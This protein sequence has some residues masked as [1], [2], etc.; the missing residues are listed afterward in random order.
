MTDMLSNYVCGTIWYS[1]Y[2]I[3]DTL[4]TPYSCVWTIINLPRVGGH[5]KSMHRLQKPE[6]V[7]ENHC[8]IQMLGIFFF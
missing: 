1:I 4:V 2:S 5:T 8:S 6:V 3:G 7:I